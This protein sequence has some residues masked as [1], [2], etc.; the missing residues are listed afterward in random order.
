M[1]VLARNDLRAL[2]RK[3]YF[4]DKAR[5]F[6]K[7]NFFARHLEIGVLKANLTIVLK[8]HR[9]D[10]LVSMKAIERSLN[11]MSCEDIKKSDECMFRQRRGP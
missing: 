8:L 6:V 5:F 10:L 2:S 9:S 4:R 3:I 1:N 7:N 11:R